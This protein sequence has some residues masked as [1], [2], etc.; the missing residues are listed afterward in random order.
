MSGLLEY[1]LEKKVSIVTND[2][3]HMIGNLR[4]F[5]QAVNVIL[6]ECFQR[7]YSKDS[8]VEEVVMGLYIIRGDNIAVIG[9]H[10]DAIDSQLDKSQIRIDGIK[11][12]SQ[13]KTNF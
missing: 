10:D 1:F 6:D 4:G 12:I 11:P 8:G 5:D 13:L 2:G 7:T 3:R 9:E